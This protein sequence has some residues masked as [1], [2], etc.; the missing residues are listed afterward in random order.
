MSIL[1]KYLYLL[2][3]LPIKIPPSYFRQVQALFMRFVWA[4]K[5]PCLP[6]SQL[7]LPKQ[8]SGLSNYIYVYMTGV[9]QCT[10]ILPNGT[11]G[12]DNQLEAAFDE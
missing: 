2:Q 11:L 1:P 6:C 4:C 3:A 10:Y 9:T 12:Q 5:K 8:F 7:Y